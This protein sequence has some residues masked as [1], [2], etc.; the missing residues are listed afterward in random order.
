MT[1]NSYA[2]IEICG[3]QHKVEVGQALVVDSLAEKE[4]S[5]LKVED[6]LLLVDNGKVLIGNPKVKG[7]FV[8]LRIKGQQRGKKVTVEKYKAKSRY[9]KKIGHRQS[10]TQLLV[11]AINS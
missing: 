10:Q 2:I 8:T 9:R 7:A 6:V 3:K 5:L 11:E 4:N 1:K